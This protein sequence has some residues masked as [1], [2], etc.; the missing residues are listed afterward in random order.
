M[1]IRQ[2]RL[3]KN[4]KADFITAAKLLEDD[5]LIWSADLDSIRHSLAKYLRE[6]AENGNENSWH[7]IDVVDRFISD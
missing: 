6:K 3:S 4:V 7:L 1:A 5:N 2:F